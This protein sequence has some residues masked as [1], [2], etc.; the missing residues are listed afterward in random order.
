MCLKVNRNTHEGLTNIINSVGRQ[1]QDYTDTVL[2]VMHMEESVPQGASR[3]PQLRTAPSGD[4]MTGVFQK[5]L[6][7]HIASSLL[8]RGLPK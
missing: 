3:V 2:T 1:V 4:L 7:F 5:R 8:T 6:P